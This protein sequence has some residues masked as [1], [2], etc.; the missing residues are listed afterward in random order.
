MLKILF[1]DYVILGEGSSE[2]V[3]FN[4]IFNRM[5]Y[6]LMAR[7]SK[8]NIDYVTGFGKF[9]LP[10]HFI[11]AN[12]FNVKVLCMFDI[13]NLENKSHKAFY[14]A[15]STYEIDNKDLFATVMLDPDLEAELGIEQSRHRV[16]KPLHIFNEVFYKKNNV[17]KIV[18]KIDLILSKF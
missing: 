17:D 18:E 2:E 7:Y 12:L 4:Y 1:A 15:F 13:D 11:L 6:D 8:L 10:F 3:L 16:E 5:D 9:Y 14:N